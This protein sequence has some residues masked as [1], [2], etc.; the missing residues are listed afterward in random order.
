M[1]SNGLGVDGDWC[2]FALCWT[3][4]WTMGLIC[5]SFSSWDMMADRMSYSKGQDG[6]LGIRSGA[7]VLVMVIPMR[8]GRDSGPGV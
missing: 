3:L 6:R 5:N 7:Q 2:T 8:G 4:S 1:W